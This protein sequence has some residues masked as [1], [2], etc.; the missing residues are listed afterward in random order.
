MAKLTGRILTVWLWN[1]LRGYLLCNFFLRIMGFQ[2]SFLLLHP[3]LLK[4]K[5]KRKEQQLR[6]HILLSGGQK[7]VKAKVV[8]YQSKGTF[9]LNGSVHSQM[10]A[11]FAGDILQRLLPLLPEGFFIMTSFG[12]FTSCFRQHFSLCGQF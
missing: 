8:L 9:N 12:A 5:A 11:P 7:S 4:I 10:D 2:P 6:S 3:A 1:F